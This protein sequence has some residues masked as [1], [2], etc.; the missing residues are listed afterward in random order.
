[1]KSPLKFCPDPDDLPT[2]SPEFFRRLAA[3]IIAEPPAL[4]AF[5]KDAWPIIEP[6]NPL[7]DEYYI[8]YMC[9]YLELVTKGEILK[10]LFNLPPRE[11]KSNI[12]TIS[13]PAWSWIM[14][15]FLR[16]L[17]CSYSSSLAVKH[18]VM[19]RNIITSSW[20][21]K[22]WGDT[23]R[24][25]PDQNQKQEYE[26][27]ARGFMLATSVDGTITGKGGDVIIEDDL[28][29]PL[30]AESDAERN[31]AISVHQSVLSSRLDNPMTGARV[32]VEQRTHAHDLTA[33]VEEHEDGWTIVRLPL[34]CE[35][36][37]TIVFPITGRRV[38]RVPGDSLS[39]RRHGPKEI[40]DFKKSMGPRT[41]TAQCQ[42]NPTAEI[43]NILK[44]NWWHYY[45]VL[46][47]GFDIIIT[48][49]DLTFKETREGSF[50]CGQVW[51]R[52]G[53]DYYLFP[54]MV[55]ERIDFVESVEAVQNLARQHP[56]ATGH[57]V[58]EKA[59]GAAVM[60]ALARK[61]PGLVPILPHGSKVARA[62][63]VTPPIAAG[64]VHLPHVSIAPWVVDFVEECAKF[65]G[66]DSE[67]NDQVDAATQ[68]LNYLGQTRYPDAEEEDDNA[69]FIDTD[70]MNPEAVGAFATA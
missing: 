34:L 8:D 15:P 17:T 4:R 46:P 12:V 47:S 52:R 14:K 37:T 29:N 10:L 6:A 43:G 67:I 42:Q 19:R 51:G 33:H 22:N 13:W 39:P 56:H 18:A 5:V 23:V 41:F 58:E 40:A 20:Y 49:W 64:N 69:S 48:S 65:R 1:M 66:E 44:R 32:I 35:R 53:A 55:R 57:L 70:G 16:F 31:R 45:L 63:A 9:E 27:T 25:A 36:K 38:V 26:N 24:L 3:N 62:V 11:G 60:S 61:L 28:I 54:T 59:N 50:V 7:Q 68:A 30:E 21:Q 2:R